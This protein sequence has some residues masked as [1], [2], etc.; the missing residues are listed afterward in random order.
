MMVTLTGGPAPSLS[1]TGVLGAQNQMYSPNY[2]EV[3]LDIQVAGAVA[4]KA[5]FYVVFAPN[6]FQAW[7]LALDAAL[8]WPGGAP[9]AVSIS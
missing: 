9:D 6:Q 3:L 7:I 4:P 8:A 2:V 5:E 1:D